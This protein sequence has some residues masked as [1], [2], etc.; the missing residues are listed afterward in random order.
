MLPPML[1]FCHL[2]LCDLCFCRLSSSS[3]LASLLTA[4]WAQCWS[5]LIEEESVATAMGIFPGLGWSYS[6]DQWYIDSCLR[7]HSRVLEEAC[8][9]CLLSPLKWTSGLRLHPSPLEG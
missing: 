8:E 7:S 3:V 4:P 9:S 6:R 1:C 5:C 2:L